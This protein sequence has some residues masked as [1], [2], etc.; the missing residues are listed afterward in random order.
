MACPNGH[1][2]GQPIACWNPGGPCA[3]P[4]EPSCETCGPCNLCAARSL[5][6]CIADPPYPPRLAERHDTA[7]ER[8]RITIRSRAARYYGD[9]T[10]SAKEVP[11]DFHPDARKWDEPDAHAELIEHLHATYDGWALATTLDGLDW[12]AP[13]PIAAR[14]L[15]WNRSTA[16]PTSGR[17]AESLEAV[18][19]VTPVARRRAGPL[20]QVPQYLAAPAPKAG[21]VG[22]KPERWTRW[23]LD[24]MA[25]DPDV[26]ELV[27]LFP[28]SGWISRAASQAV[29]L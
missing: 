20:G 17:I 1:E 8:P 12:Y 7:T 19:V 22:A 13:L 27:D 2:P 6:F 18:I 23:V 5:R 11:A 21:F 25:Y 10:R 9:G 16:Q 26:D 3:V 29:L 28:G 24:A 14:V 4:G 15:V